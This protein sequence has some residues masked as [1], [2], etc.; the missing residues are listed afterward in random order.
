MLAKIMGLSNTGTLVYLLAEGELA[1]IG[2]GP[3]PKAMRV[4]CR[5]LFLDAHRAKLRSVDLPDF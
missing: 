5:K 2:R 3:P 4:I 1:D